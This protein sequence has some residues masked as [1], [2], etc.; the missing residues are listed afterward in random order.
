MGR[1][2]REPSPFTKKTPIFVGKVVRRVYVE[3]DCE[4]IDGSCLYYPAAAWSS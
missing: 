2:L 4:L 3:E 1:R